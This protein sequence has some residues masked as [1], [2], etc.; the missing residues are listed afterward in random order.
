[1]W[2]VELLVLIYFI[3]VVVYTAIFSIAGQ[4][5]HIPT[6]NKNVDVR[7]FCVFIPC[8]KG[9]DVI[10]DVAKKALE[11]SYS[12]NYYTIVVIADSLQPETLTIL[13]KLPI[14]IIEVHFESSTKVKSLKEALNRLPDNFDYA[15]ILDTDN[16]MASDF[17]SRMNS[18]LS[19]SAR[20]VQG[21]R[22]PKNQN[23]S[24]AVL[25]GVSEAINNHIYRQGTV[26]L[27][28]SASISGSGVV[29][30]YPL[31]K[32]KIHS[33]NSVGGFDRELELL[34]LKDGVKVQ[35]LK[36]A[37]VY[38]EK[39]S[40]T[41]TFTN[42]RKRWISSQYFYLRKYFS[43]GMKALFKGNFTFFN[44]AVL[45]NVQL[46]RLINI[47]LLSSLTFFLFFIKEY[48]YFGY[49]IWLVLFIINSFSIL[50]SIPGEFYTKNLALAVL[51]LPAVFIN[52]LLLLFKL[53]GANKK[54]IHTP[55][56][57]NSNGTI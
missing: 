3:Y 50:I 42:Q 15:V 17:I 19:P 12:S 52:M 44:S 46:P 35:Y 34:L 24:L 54:F 16:I 32:E 36:D 55:H 47:G 20:A 56:G 13:R 21:Q 26:S 5:Y 30:E 1:M 51:R 31:F 2:I 37:I 25:D 8:Y 11:Q 39:V 27:G 48:L 4:F 6:E 53:K 28:L 7:T 29:F 49:T 38:D 33:M 18:V 40:Q 43:V 41:K 9:D 22:K 45:R 23:N 14:Q 57:V 10:V